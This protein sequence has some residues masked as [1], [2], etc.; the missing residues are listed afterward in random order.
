MSADLH[1]HTRLSDGSLGLDDLITLARDKQITTI[2]ITDHDCLAGT[3]RGKMIG[4]RQGVTVIPGV[5]L[6]ATDETNGQEVHLLAYKCDFPDRL[7]GLCRRNSLERKK[8]SHYM[9]LKTQKLYPITKEIVVKCMSGSTNIYIPHLM[10]ALMECGFTD[11]IYGS[12]YEELFTPDGGRSV[13]VTPKYESVHSVLAAIKEAGGIAVL[14][15]P[16]RC[17]NKELLPSLTAEGLDGVEAYTPEITEQ[18]REALV[19]FAKKNK[20]LTTGGS[21]FKGFYGSR[22]LSVGDCELPKEC[23][24]ELLTYKAR[25]KKQQRRAEADAKAKAEAEAAAEAETAE[26]AAV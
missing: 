6:S 8:I 1:C 5:E 16:N 9:M 14:A 13:L 23:V 2:A 10:H 15:H 12:L 11:R 4:E 26:P 19:K 24:Q 25:Q 7:E 17:L 3:A 22:V 18:E 21:N 20:M